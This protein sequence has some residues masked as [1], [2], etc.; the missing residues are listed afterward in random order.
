M[1]FA[2]LA[3]FWLA[4]L[5]NDFNIFVACLLASQDSLESADS[6]CD[7]KIRAWLRDRKKHANPKRKRSRRGKKNVPVVT[8][9]GNTPKRHTRSTRHSKREEQTKVFSPVASSMVLTPVAQHVKQ[10]E[11]RIKLRQK[12][13]KKPIP[14]VTLL[15]C[16]LFR[17]CLPD[18]SLTCSECR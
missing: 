16:F 12:R 3:C 9:E 13:N 15:V 1:S 11:N 4:C 17:Y 2:L 5:S 18:G 8:L 14:M 6:A 10:K 7:A